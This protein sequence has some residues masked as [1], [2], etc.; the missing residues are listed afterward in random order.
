MEC[1]RTLRNLSRDE[2]PSPVHF[3]VADEFPAPE[4]M[5]SNTPEENT[6]ATC[7]VAHFRSGSMQIPDEGENSQDGTFWRIRI[8]R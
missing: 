1:A 2:V 7:I 5:T 4:R 6:Y 3:D 8:P